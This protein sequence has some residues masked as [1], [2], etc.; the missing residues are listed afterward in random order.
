MGSIEEAKKVLK[1][2]A[3][4]IKNLISTIDRN[5]EKAV[6]IVASC[7]GRIVVMGMGK[8]G[9]VGKKIAATLAS[10]GT[11]AFFLHPAEGILGDVGMMTEG[12]LVLALSHSGET[13]EIEKLLPVIRRMNLKLIAITGK[14]KSKLAKKSDLVINVKVK[15][16]ACPYNLVPTASTTAMLAMGDALA[17]SLLKRKKFKKEDFARLHPGGILGKRLL[18]KVKDIMRKGKDNP[19]IH[20][21]KT[22][23]EA[24]LVMT[25][26]RLGATSVVDS[27]G[28]LVGFF[29]D[30]DL[31]RR[32]Q[33]DEKI[34]N[35]K[36]HTVMTKNPKTIT[37]DILAIEAAKVMQEKKFDNIPVVDGKGYPIGIVDE[38]D[39][40]SEGIL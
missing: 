3:R 37:H 9:L 13:E 16:E 27:S 2:E 30:G 15:E 40:L 19:V 25:K 8:S 5:F 21:E 4:A 17:I 32:L 36:I 39:L 10:T 35:K 7:K 29:T 24:L 18:L 14:P 20:Q 26:T 22:V 33:K 28:K 38:R 12:D 31:R 34:L 23:R 11:P 6:E 1:I